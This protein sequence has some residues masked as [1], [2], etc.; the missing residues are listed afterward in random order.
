MTTTAPTTI[1]LIGMMG[2]GKTAVGR[3]LA[4]R[5]GWRYVDN[6]ELVRAATGRAPEDIDATDGEAAL[7]HAEAAALRRALTAPPPLIA[8]AAAW[9]VDDPPSLRLLRSVPAV[10][11]LRARPETLHAR[12]GSGQGRRDEATDAGWLRAR[13]AGRAAAYEALATVVIDTDDLPAD[14]VAERILAALDA[15]GSRTASHS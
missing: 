9:V 15:Q 4:A 3:A 1:V 13:L 11:Y 2:S 14:A 5:T 7:H 12:I 6:D 8:A 10:V